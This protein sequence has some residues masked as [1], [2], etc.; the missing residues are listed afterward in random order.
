MRVLIAGGG[1]AGHVFPAIALAERLERDHGATVEFVGSPRGQ[2]ARL[3]PA[4]GFEF[5]AVAAE[6]MPRKVSAAA[7]RAPFTALAS[8]RACRPIV[9]R[10]DVVVGMGGYASLPAVL[11]ARWMKKPLVLHEQNAVPGIVNRLAAR[12]ARSVAVSFTD[13]LPRFSS[14]AKRTVI[15][16]NPVRERVLDVA[17]RRE[18]LA[19]EACA[20]LDLDPDALTVLLSGGSLGALAVDRLFAGALPLLKGRED[21]QVLALTGPGHLDVVEGAAS[22]LTTP[23]VRALEFLERIEL[24]YAVA[25]LALSRAGAGNIAELAVCGVPAVLVPYPHA[26]ENHQEANARELERAGAARVVLQGSLTPKVLVSTLTDL[27]ADGEARRRMGAAARAWARPDAAAR[28]ADL[29]VE[30]A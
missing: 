15:T 22:S 10:A 4:A 14:L 2:E 6:Q 12:W 3:V 20:E 26:T 25:D 18:S 21:L 19:K 11:A 17:A 28:L 9:A 5:H 7:L 27:L 23:R 8:V 29:V 30:A 16:G 24:A 13:A 1:T